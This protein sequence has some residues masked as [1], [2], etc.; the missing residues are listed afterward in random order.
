MSDNSVEFNGKL[1]LNDIKLEDAGF[2]ECFTSNGKSSRVK[3]TVH[4]TNKYSEDDEDYDASDYDKVREIDTDVEL[5]CELSHQ[6][7][8][9]LR[10]R[11]LDGVN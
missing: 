10:W 1:F 7:E 6:N 4:G 5:T 3:L 9:E 11:K 8:N 2:Y